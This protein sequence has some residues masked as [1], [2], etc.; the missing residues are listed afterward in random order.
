MHNNAAVNIALGE[1]TLTMATDAESDLCQSDQNR[2]VLMN[3][4]SCSSV[5]VNH[6]HSLLM[7]QD[8]N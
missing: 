4:W 7:I 8:H 1:H 5:F 6:V 2:L 3:E